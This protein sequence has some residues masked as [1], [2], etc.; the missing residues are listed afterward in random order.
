MLVLLQALKKSADS[1][2]DESHIYQRS[3]A[4]LAFADI[5]LTGNDRYVS[6]FCDAGGT[7]KWNQTFVYLWWA[8]GPRASLLSRRIRNRPVR[9][10]NGG[11][12]ESERG[13]RRA[14]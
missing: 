4:K 14:E 7:S 9:S 2:Q 12:F 13:E 6:M 5:K 8:T 1:F 10:V 11:Y 3:E